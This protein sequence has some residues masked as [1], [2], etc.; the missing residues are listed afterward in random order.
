MLPIVPLDRDTIE[1]GGTKVEYRSLSRDEVGQLSGFGED[2]AAAEVFALS[3]ATGVT[4]DEAREWRKQVG[5]KVVA[6][7]LTAI[8]LISGISTRKGPRGNP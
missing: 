7:L 8:A 5:S 3:R 2:T 4:D 6:D 1:I